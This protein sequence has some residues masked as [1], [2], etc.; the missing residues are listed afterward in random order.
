MSLTQKPESRSIRVVSADGNTEVLVASATYNSKSINCSFEIIN[1]E[2]CTAHP[3]DVQ[4]AIS[5]FIA[6]LNT[7]LSASELPTITPAQT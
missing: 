2:Y 4:N 6:D 3:Q 5:S 1:P 7:V